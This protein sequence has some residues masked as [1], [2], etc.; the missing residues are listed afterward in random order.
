L[1]KRAEG[2]TYYSGKYDCESGTISQEKGKSG[3]Q[4]RD[5]KAITLLKTN[6]EYGADKRIN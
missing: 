4:I 5:K 2:K 3:E 1:A 6:R